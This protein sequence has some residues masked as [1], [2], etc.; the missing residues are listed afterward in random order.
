MVEL[1]PKEYKL[2]RS[3]QELPVEWVYN[4]NI[5]LAK[6]WLREKIGNR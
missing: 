4:I 1:V 6:T 2:R 5:I 3:V